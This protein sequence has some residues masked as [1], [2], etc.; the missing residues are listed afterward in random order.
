M[1]TAGGQSVKRI[2]IYC[3]S[4]SIMVHLPDNQIKFVT[5]LQFLKLAWFALRN[6]IEV[7]IEEKQ[8]QEWKK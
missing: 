2:T 7:V 4:E 1:G 8:T 5:F 3:S 6:N